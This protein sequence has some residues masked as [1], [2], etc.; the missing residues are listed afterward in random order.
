MAAVWQPAHASEPA[1]CRRGRMGRRLQAQP[2][3]AE[4]LEVVLV[5][6]H[7]LLHVGRIFEPR[8]ERHLL[9]AE[10][11]LAILI[12]SDDDHIHPLVTDFDQVRLGAFNRLRRTWAVPRPRRP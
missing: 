1:N 6:D 4:R 9:I 2:F 11:R 8:V 10:R 7:D 12:E 3:E 5:F